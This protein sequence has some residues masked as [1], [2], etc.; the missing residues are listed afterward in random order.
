MN[1]EEEIVSV[2]VVDEF[3]DLE[4]ELDSNPDEV[5]IDSSDIREEA[6]EIAIKAI[7]DGLEFSGSLP[8]VRRIAI[9]LIVAGSLL[10]LWFGVL[11]IAADPS[12]ILGDNIQSLNADQIISGLIVT[13][14]ID[15]DSGGDT[16]EGVEV[17]LL[18]SSGELVDR[19]FTD[20]DGRFQFSN[21]TTEVRIIE[22]QSEGNITERR[23]LVP[24]EV[25]QLTITLRAGDGVNEV[26][27]RRV[28]NLED[29][30]RLGTIVAFFTVFSSA[31]GFGAAMETLRGNSYRRAQ[32]LSGLA[33][34]SRGGVFIGPGL[35]LGGMAL[36]R[37]AKQQFSDQ[38]ETEE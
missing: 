14:I 28:S 18:S 26:D 24:G 37:L 8:T 11:S 31:L 35:I 20:Q 2:R 7:H 23:V 27:L 19:K 29:S 32:W 1:E 15:G 6:S 4:A 16:P 25:S 34:F 22:V 9:V 30:V 10:G 33:L 12:D 38:I 21:Q 3:D 17:R 5:R 13:E 36:N